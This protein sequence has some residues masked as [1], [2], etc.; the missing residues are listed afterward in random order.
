MWNH[1][2][3]S[4]ATG[5]D[6]FQ[7]AYHTPHHLETTGITEVNGLLKSQLQIQLGDNTL[8]WR[9][10][11][12]HDT[13][14]A[15]NQGPLYSFVSLIAR[16]VQKSKVEVRVDPL[17]ITPKNPL[18]EILLPG[19]FELFWFGD[20]LV[21]QMLPSGDTTTVLS[22]NERWDCHL[23]ILGS[24]CHWT[25]GKNAEGG[26]LIYWM[27]SLNLIA[28]GKLACCTMAARRAV[29]RT[30]EILGGAS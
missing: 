14:Y 17:A 19:N 1:S 8:K 4:E 7:W 25:T 21:W 11:V 26:L 12:L 3:R 16:I 15:L 18:A 2:K 28:K 24:T 20:L 30:R 29:S 6:G 23:N 13:V 5:Y 10:P 9:G 22:W 27:E